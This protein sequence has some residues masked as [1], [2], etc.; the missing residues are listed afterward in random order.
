MEQNNTLNGTETIQVS[1]LCHPLTHLM[2]HQGDNE[3]FR[4]AIVQALESARPN[5]DPAVIYAFKKTGYLFDEEGKKKA[6]ANV[7][8]QY[9]EAINDWRENKGGRTAGQGR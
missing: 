8:R 3:G 6:P 1:Q 5:V 7:Q 4:N 2:L 9:D